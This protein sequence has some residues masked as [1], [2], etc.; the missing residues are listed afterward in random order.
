MLTV[1]LGVGA[2]SVLHIERRPGHMHMVHCAATVQ[3]LCAGFLRVK[4][5]GLCRVCKPGGAVVGRVDEQAWGGHA[6][7]ARGERHGDWW[8]ATGDVFFYFSGVRRGAPHPN[9]AYGVR[10]F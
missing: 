2:P 3:H 8:R 9:F 6:T 1:L 7:R 5:Q 10:H 4:A